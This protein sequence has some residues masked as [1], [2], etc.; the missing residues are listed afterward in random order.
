MN[1][2]NNQKEQLQAS[3]QG[4]GSA[5]NRGQERSE[6]QQQ[7]TRLSEGQ[8]QDIGSQLGNDSSR[9]ASLE[10]LGQLSGRD[11]A[12]GGSGDQMENEN[13]GDRTDR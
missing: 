4:T 9:V 7:N 10:D 3:Q 12:S 5:E 11:D 8:K 6:Q 13:S 2:E 1:R